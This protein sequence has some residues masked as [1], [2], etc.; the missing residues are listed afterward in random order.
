MQNYFTNNKLE[1]KIENEIEDKE[2]VASSPLSTPLL[3]NKDK[4]NKDNKDNE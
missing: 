2:V 4:D 3:N 1:D